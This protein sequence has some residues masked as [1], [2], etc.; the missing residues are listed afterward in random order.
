[1]TLLQKLTIRHS[2]LR[3]RFN[4]LAGA[5]KALTDEQRGELDSLSVELR[6]IEPKIRA[7]TMGASELREAQLETQETKERGELETRAR[8][9]G[10]LSAV[11]SGRTPD[12]A[13]RELQQ[14]LGIGAHQIPL[15]LLAPVEVRTSG[16]T[17]APTAKAETQAPIMGNVFPTAV[18]SWMGIPTPRVPVGDRNYPILSTSATV[19]TPA[20]GASAA[21]SAAAFTVKTLQPSRLQASVFFR[22]EDRAAFQ[23]MEEALRRDLG[24]AVAD[25]MDSEILAGGSSLGLL[26]GA[27]GTAPTDPSSQSA[28]ADYKSA[29]TGRVDGRYADS[30]SSVKVV[31]G[32][33]TMQHAAAQYK[34]SETAEDAWAMLGR[35]SGGARVS[36]H[37]PAASSNVQSTLFVRGT[38]GAVAPIWEGASVLVDP[39]TQRSSGEVILSI[40]AMWNFG[41]YRTGNFARVKFKLAA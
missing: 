3:E 6:E 19:R 12:G 5:E 4:T 16:Q 36:A 18:H 17:S 25:K 33:A 14:E 29:L 39:Y 37:V 23:G 10:I 11:I 2:E 30:P 40:I 27:L 26:T 21:S 8:L 9:S 13:E 31:A 22:M 1:M 32:A 20:A 15:A 28:F 41:V 34:A 24:A 35:M 38:G 7:A